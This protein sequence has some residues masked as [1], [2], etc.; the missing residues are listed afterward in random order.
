MYVAPVDLIFS[1]YLKGSSSRISSKS[2]MISFSS[3][4]EEDHLK[5]VPKA[6]STKKDFAYHSFNLQKKMQGSFLNQK[7]DK[8]FLGLYRIPIH[9]FLVAIS[10]FF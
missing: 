8:H 2:A 10:L 6:K 9:T 7:N 3:L 1:M 5:N 4:T